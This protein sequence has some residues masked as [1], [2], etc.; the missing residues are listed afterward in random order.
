MLTFTGSTFHETRTAKRI[1]LLGSIAAVS[2]NACEAEREQ[3][4]LAKSTASVAIGFEDDGLWRK[5]CWNFV[6]DDT[7]SWRAFVLNE[8]VV[9]VQD[10]F[11][12]A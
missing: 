10:G 4:A 5:A 7:S 11:D 8:F 3:K 2:A 12:G 1:R 9:H 6:D